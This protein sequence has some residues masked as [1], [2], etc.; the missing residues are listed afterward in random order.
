MKIIFVGYLKKSGSEKRELK[1]ESINDLKKSNS[2]LNPIDDYIKFY[3]DITS[4]FINPILS[5]KAIYYLDKQAKTEKLEINNINVGNKNNKEDFTKIIKTFLNSNFY[6]ISQK[7]IIYHFITDVREP[8]SEKVE[9][10]FNS[11]VSAFLSTSKANDLS[12]KLYY[13][14]MD[15]LIQIIN[16]Y[17]MNEGYRETKNKTRN[18]NYQRTSSISK[19]INNDNKII[20]DYGCPEGPYPKMH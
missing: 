2:I 3:N 16:N 19:I 17:L 6:F 10:A 9:G 18:S 13:R 5:E 12:K 14:K 20:I 15:D 8:L 4:N 11:I 1:A 7:Y